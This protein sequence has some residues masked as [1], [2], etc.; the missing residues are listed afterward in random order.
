ML[1]GKRER[2][3]L[4]E[5]ANRA[6]STEQKVAAAEKATR[7]KVEAAIDASKADAKVRQA[8]KQLGQ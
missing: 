5:L 7:E 8:A 4:Q 2:L 3:D 1:V 6:A